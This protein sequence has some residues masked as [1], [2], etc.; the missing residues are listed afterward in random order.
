MRTIHRSGPR[1][2][3]LPRIPSPRR[4]WRGLA[5]TALFGAVALSGCADDG[6]GAAANGWAGGG[7]AAA[8]PATVPS[9]MEIELGD[10]WV[11]PASI[12]IPAG[13]TMTLDVVNT[14]AMPHDLAVGGTEG[15]RMLDPGEREQ[16]T[17]GP[18]AASAEAWCTVPG[19]REAGM[20]MDIV[21]TG[22]AD[23]GG[24]VAA[25][26]SSPVDD[27]AT[28]DFAAAPDP[29]WQ[30]YDPALA[31]APGGTEHEITLV[32]DEVVMEVAPGV[33]QEMWVFGDSFPGPVLRGAG[34]RPVHR[35]AGERRG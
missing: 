19:H 31:P 28:I 30:P 29:D 22:G 32:A 16:I 21:V 6:P 4:T 23:H 33:T 14:G 15:T 7:G 11:R 26:S 17:I 18:F 24:D 35:D 3:H 27:S 9:A 34:R 8:D 10:L 12:E 5:A 2:S 1:S 13:A 25:G 20:E